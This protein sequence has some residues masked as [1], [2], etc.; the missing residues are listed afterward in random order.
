MLHQLEAK[1]M[2]TEEWAFQLD[3]CYISLQKLRVSKPFSPLT[4]NSQFH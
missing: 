3:I 2:F 1:K 4:K